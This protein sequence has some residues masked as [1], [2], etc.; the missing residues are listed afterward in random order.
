MLFNSHFFIFVFLP[1]ALFVYI[2]LG[3]LSRNWALRWIIVAS[4][5]FYAWWRPA[6]VFII[7]PAMLVNF[8]VAKAILFHH[9]ENNPGGA[10]AFLVIGIVFNVC[11]LGYF[12]YTNFLL[13]ATNDI[14]ASDFTLKEIVLPLGI[15]FITFQKIAFLIDVHGK[16][17]SSF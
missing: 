17:I 5:V 2:V 4:L 11:V 9:R 8:A 3:Q 16:R 10:R 7:I 13:S 15:S 14:F 1:T 12:K 6:N